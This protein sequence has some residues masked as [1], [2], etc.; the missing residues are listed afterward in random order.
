[1]TYQ[2]R[3]LTVK[4]TW[5]HLYMY[6]SHFYNLK[7]RLQAL[8]SLDMK[9]FCND[10]VT[11]RFVAKVLTPQKL[12][13]WGSTNT[14]SLLVIRNRSSIELH[15]RKSIFASQCRKF[16]SP[17]AAPTVVKEQKKTGVSDIL[18]DNLG[19]I[20]LLAIAG[21]IGTIIRSSR[22]TTNRN[23][24]RDTVEIISALDPVEIDELRL[25]N[26]ELTPDVFRTIARDLMDR[27]P[28][29]TCSYHEFTLTTRSTMAKMKGGAFTIQLGHLVDRVVVKILEKYGATADDPLPLALWLTTLSLTLHSSVEE[30]IQVLYDVMEKVNSPVAFSQVEDLVGFLQDTC[31]LPPDT[32]IVPTETKYP[33][34]EW[35]RGTPDQ[36]VPWDGARNDAMD[37]E[38]F[39][40]ILRS[41]SVCAWGECYH[42]KKI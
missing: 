1:M 34:Q 4:Q 35:E 16:S 13:L 20:F 8:K 9:I 37:L 30:R 38:A 7:L 27:Y 28:Q 33:A 36:L 21:V 22:S 41:K 26:S 5:G 31:Q 25:A 19:K 24:I 3:I 39:S 12:N 18:L 23:K 11:R 2:N 6:H 32:Q 14:N 15:D 42:K 40:S 10:I 29:N 17:S